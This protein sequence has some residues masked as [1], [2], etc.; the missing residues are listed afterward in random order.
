MNAAELLVRHL[1]S[2]DVRFF[3][4]IP[5][6]AL[7]PIYNAVHESMQ[8]ESI[9]TKHEAGAAFMADG[10]ARVSGNVGV[11]GSTT[12][13]GATNLLTGIASAHADSV[14]VMALTAQV[15][16]R[17]F[18]RGAF[19]ESSAEGTDVVNIFGEVTKY[20]AMIINP[21]K[22]GEMT[23][24]A[25]K[26]AKSGRPGP[27]HLNLPSDVMYEEVINDM[28]AHSYHFASAPFDRMAVKQAAHLLMKSKNPAM[29][30]GNG[31]LIGRATEEILELAE[32]LDI[33]VATTPK[34]KSAFP[35]THEL[36]LGVFGFAGSPLAES[37]LLDNNIDVL[38]AI[39][40]SFNEWATHGWDQRLAY[41]KEVIQVDIDPTQFGRVYPCSV[42]LQGDSKAVV[43]ELLFE[44]RRQLQLNDSNVEFRR[45]LTFKS[46]HE[47]VR[48]PYKAL[49]DEMPLKPQRLMN[50]LRASLPDDTIFFA[51][52]GSNLAWAIH[53]LKVNKPR[54]FV[55]GI[56]FGSM[57]Y[58]VAAAI[59]GKLA[60]PERPVV[61]I[62]GDGGFLMNGMEVATAVN[63]D[64]PV[65]WVVENNAQLGMVWHGQQ[66]SARAHV[67]AS[68]FKRVDFVKI[69]EGLG[70]RA[71]RVERPG[72][73]SRSLMDD[74]IKA[75]QPTVIDVMIDAYERPPIQS[76]IKSLEM[77]A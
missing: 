29:I 21:D 52:I 57:G 10:Y 39:G 34:G 41:N 30:L 64:I 74:I 51:D 3:F 6:G 68:E 12:G 24:R 20:S 54:T 44:L 69:A 63:H 56:G 26:L 50:D 11:C 73:I 4:G 14:P 36:A 33:P 5:G 67:T 47:T 18:G 13:P 49:S 60:A 19:Q 75:G 70:A 77:I 42:G 37:F 23:R 59:G 7:E 25:L 9:L 61:S 16:T 76:R 53:Y 2:E 55:A 45:L 28:P 8:I 40:T 65:I 43:R 1:E 62:V 32:L 31:A 22:T 27:V 38:L 17:S 71:I 35:E 46:M 15:P 58:G 66:M 72:E 48:D